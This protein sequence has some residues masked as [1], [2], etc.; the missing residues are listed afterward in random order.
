M[1]SSKHLNL[2]KT[3]MTVIK[4]RTNKSATIPVTFAHKKHLA[5]YYQWTI[6]AILIYIERSQEHINLFLI[7]LD[8]PS[9][10]TVSPTHQFTELEC[11]MLLGNIVLNRLLN[12]HF[13]TLPFYEALQ[14][15]TKHVK[16]FN[17]HTFLDILIVI[18]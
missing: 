8:Y 11:L 2:Y 18:Q 1:C 12:T 9:F 3:T 10:R 7:R 4:P 14:P 5:G 16:N 6:T 15:G 17:C 13:Y